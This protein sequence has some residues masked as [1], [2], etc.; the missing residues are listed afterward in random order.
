MSNSALPSDRSD[1]LR[2]CNSF[3]VSAVFHLTALVALGLLSVALDR[4]WPGVE[5]YAQVTD[6]QD[7]PLTADQIEDLS[8]F[9]LV[10]DSSAAM[11]PERLF[12]FAAIA[13]SDSASL[14]AAFDVSA[15]ASGLEGEGLGDF[16][17]G[18]GDGDTGLAEFFGVSGY[19]GSFV[20]VVDMSG[21]MSEQG[22]YERARYELI[23]SIENL[24]DKQ[25][26]FVIFYNDGWYPMDA[27]EPV[28]A[29]PEQVEKTRRWVENVWPGGGTVPLPALLFALELKPDAIYFL[30]DGQFDP[31]TVRRLRDQN[32]PRTRGR[33][34]SAA[35]APR[36]IPIHTIAFVNRETVGIMRTIARDSDGKFRFVP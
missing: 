33:R 25:K 3:L 24:S 17:M 15:E 36:P 20:Y 21:S 2:D 13:T 35:D 7:T 34:R 11:G 22:K 16:G 27:D 8:Q 28:L 4:D 1:W 6:G 23:R 10:S 5:L 32:P 19:G 18:G 29:T 31:G 26:Y 12:D 14:N 30:S 9:E